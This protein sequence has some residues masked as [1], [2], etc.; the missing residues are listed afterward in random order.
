MVTSGCDYFSVEG[1]RTKGGRKRALPW[2]V[3]PAMWEW[4]IKFLFLK[5]GKN[6]AKVFWAWNS[7]EFRT[8]GE[9]NF[10]EMM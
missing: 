4:V 3:V 2:G 6:C 7:G 5:G 1:K 10:W 9:H 8:E